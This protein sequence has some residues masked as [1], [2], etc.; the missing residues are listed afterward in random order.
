MASCH[1][2]R[3]GMM[4]AA[5]WWPMA[6][7]LLA[8]APAACAH[9]PVGSLEI[10]TR[11]GIVEGARDGDVPSWKGVPFAALPVDELRRRAPRPVVKR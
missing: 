5:C 4:R 1:A 2:V 11:A 3:G 6:A 10:A 8:A 9:R 7:A